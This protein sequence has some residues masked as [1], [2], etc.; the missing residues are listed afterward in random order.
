MV[1]NY[2]KWDA[3]ELSDDSDIEVHPNV[4]KRSFIR[5]KQNQIHMERDK[6]RHEIKT[7]KYERIVNDGLLSRIDALLTAFREHAAQAVGGK[8]DEFIMNAVLDTSLPPDQDTPPEPPADVHYKTKQP[9]YSEMIASLLDQV[10]KDSHIGT[11]DW[12]PAYVAGISAHKTKVEELQASLLARLAELEKQEASK[13]TSDSIQ[14]GFSTSSIAKAAPEPTPAPAPKA[15]KKP[16]KVKKVKG[17]AIET[18][19]VL[20]PAA[21]KRAQLKRLDSGGQTSG[22]D[23]DVEDAVPDPNSSSS[24]DDAE[25][26]E[27]EED[28]EVTPLGREFSQF[29]I[30]DY[31][32]SLAFI[33]QHPSLLAERE[34]DGLLMEAFNAGLESKLTYAKQCVHQG[35]LLQYCRSLGRDGV[36]LFFK[37]ITTPGHN[38]QKVFNDDVESTSQRIVKRT[39]EIAQERK[40]KAE[41][42]DDVEGGVEQIQLHAVDPNTEILIQIPRAEGEAL[43][44]TTAADPAK[45]APAP[46]LSEEEKAARA[47]FDSFPPGLQRAM[48]SRSL[49]RI[50][51]VLGK[52]S[53]S[54]AEEI[55]ELMGRFGMLRMEEGVIDGTTEEGRERIKMLEKEGKGQEQGHGEGEVLVEGV[56]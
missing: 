37:R 5:A 31:K 43:P 33:G 9:R 41:A 17:T 49:D 7:L 11:E 20:N 29:K 27:E 18:V 32:G 8:P 25:A 44:A 2:S 48:A 45:D 4:D 50:N 28:F 16:K 26:D 47:A 53:V 13:I 1:V 23:A 30:G 6:R 22:A 54:E 51:E 52:M 24:D 19:E 38:A 12:Y 15:E 46:P 39:K 14:T 40:E 36:G 55:V 35:L 3:L 34:T 21:A 42:G 56:D 10:K